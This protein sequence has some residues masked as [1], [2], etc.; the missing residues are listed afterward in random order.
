M[1]HHWGYSKHNGPENW[2]KDF[3]IANGDRQSP[4]D[5][6]TATAQHDP[7]L[8]PLLISYDKAASK[9]IVNNGHSFNV[10]FDDSQDNAVLKGG[11]LSDSYRLIQFHF[12]WGSSDGQGSEHT[13]NK[14]NMLQSFTWFTGTPNMGTLEKLCSNRMDWLFWVFF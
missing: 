3:P 5:I 2:H 13:V 12:H 14:K 10:E 6:D 7:A 11:P 1:S 4:V 9:S 8:Q